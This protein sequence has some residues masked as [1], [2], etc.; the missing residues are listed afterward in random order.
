LDFDEYNKN[1][2]QSMA[3]LGSKLKK[4]CNENCGSGYFR[5]GTPGIQKPTIKFNLV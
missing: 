4:G 2:K 1:T 3:D 5:R